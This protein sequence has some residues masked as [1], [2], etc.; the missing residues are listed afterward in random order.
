LDEA[1]KPG[2]LE[3]DV[4]PGSN[5]VEACDRGPYLFAILL[6]LRSETSGV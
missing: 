5:T 3:D 4:S 2:F 1:V 6:V